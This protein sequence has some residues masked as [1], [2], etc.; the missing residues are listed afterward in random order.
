MSVNPLLVQGIVS[1]IIAGGIYALVAL[2]FSLITGIMKIVNF[3]HGH[4]VVLG[5]YLTMVLWGALGWDPYAILVIVLPIGFLLG[6]ILQKLFVEHILDA[7]HLNQFTLTLGIMI[8]LENAMLAAFGGEFRGV[9]TWYTAQSISFWDG[10]IYINISRIFAFITAMVATGALYFI[11]QRTLLGKSMRAAADDREGAGLVGIN[12]GRI[13][14]IAMG[15]SGVFAVL[16]G[17]AMISHLIIIP[18]FGLPLVI[19]AFIIVVLGSAGSVPGVIVGGMLLGLIENIGQ[20]YIT[21]SLAWSV[22]LLVL[23][24]VILFR[25]EGIFGRRA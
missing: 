5:M 23:I 1:G 18:T 11:F 16:A 10:Q 25:P 24:V 12:V 2:G 20:V 19:R 21:P 8:L 13:Y 22:A 17:T 9:T 3:A 15:L 7:P 4:I 6:I 14:L